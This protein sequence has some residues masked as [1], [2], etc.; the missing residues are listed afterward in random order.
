MNKKY[1]IFTIINTV[2][3]IALFFVTLMVWMANMMQVAAGGENGG[4][5]TD[6]LYYITLPY[7]AIP[8]IAIIGSWIAWYKKSKKYSLIFLLLP[9]AYSLVMSVTLFGFFQFI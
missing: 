1:L 7:P 4:I 9:W 2:L 3:C 8:G 5:L 6:I